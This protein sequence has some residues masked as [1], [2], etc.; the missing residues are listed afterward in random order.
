MSGN[1]NSMGM[2]EVQNHVSSHPLGTEYTLQGVMRFL[3][4]EW[5][6]HERDRNAWEIER[7]E[8]KA[9]IAKMEGENRSGKKMQES[10]S[11]HI[12]MLEQALK[13]ERA[14]AKAFLS[15]GSPTTSDKDVAEQTN[16]RIKAELR[17]RS[18]G[19]KPPNPRHHNSFLDVMSDAPSPY[20]QESQRQKSRTYLEKCLQEIT[21]LLTPPANPP[22]LQ[23]PPGPTQDFTG[24]PRFSNQP[25]TQ[26]TLEEVYLHQQQRQKNHH[27][28]NLGMTQPSPSPNHQPPPVPSVSEIPVLSH[29][30]ESDQQSN[31]QSRDQGDQ[32]SLPVENSISMTGDFA[33]HQSQSSITFPLAASE[34]IEKVTHSYDTY[35]RP[36]PPRNDGGDVTNHGVPEVS[37]ADADGWNFDDAPLAASDGN[38]AALQR[39]DI[40]RF[41][42]ANH[43]PHALTKSPPRSGSGSA[44]RKSSI[45][46]RRSDGS[47][48]PRDSSLTAAQTHL[49]AES[50][51]FKVRFA[52]RGHLD[53]VRAVI[54]T[55][56]GSPSEPEICTTGDDGV[57]KRWIIPVSYS[58]FGPHGANV[59]KDLD[60]TSYFTHRGHTGT[61][62]SL[63]ACPSSPN[64]STGGRAAGDGW[65][66]SGGQ[67]A[68]IRVWERGRVDPKATLDGHTDAIWTVCVLPATCSAVFG[69]DSNNY[70]GPD[71]IL[72]ASGSADGTI[73]IWAVSSPPQLTSPHSGSRRGVGGSRRHSVTSGSGFPSSPQPS[74]ATTTPF[75]CTL[76]HTI[77]RPDMYSSPTS[78]NPISV[79]GDT[80]VV[81]YSDA[82]VRIFDTR[83]GEEAVS[84]AS[85]ETYD[86]T[87]AT[88]VNAVVATAV[89]LDGSLSVDPSRGVSEEEG[90]VHGATGSAGIEGVV[91]S[92]HE[93]RYIR[94]FDANSGQ[95]TYTM[96]AHP[97]AISSLSLS[98]D[99][100]E[101]VSAGHDASLRFWSL[102]KRSCTQEITSHRLMRGEGVC[103]VVWSSDGRWVV[104]GGGDGVVK[105][106]AR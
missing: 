29:S 16:E 78:I 30:A 86:G 69:G 6:R 60:I 71:R 42:N 81:A 58:N 85:L 64:F 15:E 61:V 104:S 65:I 13:R 97:S 91:I 4:T 34:D 48:D 32:Q 94:F 2:G 18:S 80:F 11:K 47:H 10:L 72:L 99:G 50:A 20:R 59:G 102:E 9:R 44:R 41:P 98:P 92:G 51:N 1:G 63:T 90:M 25:Q 46:R 55:G 27:Q 39:A 37:S 38:E 21:Y 8:M 67:D 84:M 31:R 36:V 12:S 17:N 28:A 93:D 83:T 101:L 19:N 53:V 105:V 57:I 45:S 22:P 7:A 68:T 52:L 70:G 95:C 77:D 3:Q 49:R 54:F 76:V 14:K 35:G 23:Q 75:H 5:H 82:S 62:T 26:P 87:P 56:G 79:T 74:T 40:D 73:K 43:V 88:G 96:L 66:F 89:G 33:P 106:F 24:G 100:R 103:T